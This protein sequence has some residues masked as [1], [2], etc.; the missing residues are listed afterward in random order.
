MD[1]APATCGLET[2][3]DAGQQPRFPC[4]LCGAVL[5]PLAGQLRCTRCQFTLCT[6]C[7]GE[8]EEL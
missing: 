2:S 8:A 7:E 5:L 3:A 4:P 6:A 1:S